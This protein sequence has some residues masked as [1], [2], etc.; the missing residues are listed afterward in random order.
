M[1]LWRVFDQ[2]PQQK[3]IL[4]QALDRFDEKAVDEQAFALLIGM[5]NIQKS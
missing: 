4:A 2:L 3:R 5:T 1:S